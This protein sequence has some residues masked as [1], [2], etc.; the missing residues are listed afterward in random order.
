MGIDIGAPG[1]TPIGAAACGIISSWG[2]NGGYGNQV[3]IRHSSTTTTC[4]AHLSSFSTS[5]RS[6]NPTARPVDSDCYVATGQLIGR[7]GTTGHSTGNHLHY[8]VKVNG[9]FVNPYSYLFSG[10]RM[11]GTPVITGGSMGGP[12]LVSDEG[13]EQEVTSAASEPGEGSAG[14]GSLMSGP[15]SR[16]SAQTSEGGV[17][18]PSGD[19]GDGTV[20][21]PGHQPP[22]IEPEPATMDAGPGA[23]GTAGEVSPREHVAANG[24]AGPPSSSSEAVEAPPRVGDDL[25]DGPPAGVIPD[26]EPVT[27]P[28]EAR[29][30]R[31][32]GDDSPGTT[33]EDGDQVG[34]G[35]A[36]SLQPF[37]GP[38]LGQ[39]GWS[40]PPLSPPA[41][42]PSPAIGRT[43]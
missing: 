4:Y 18:L 26:Q 41:C 6:C 3:C 43:G 14:L 42:P 21:D 37:P 11:S 30:Q 20:R 25:E 31:N 39:C 38:T 40:N 1:G 2:W 7:V 15:G 28:G 17:A 12:D 29:D 10:Q 19:G 32:A 34:Q 8:E 9:S 22:D 23:G 33:E 27:E 35:T 16:G 36:K 24:A 5:T 13:F